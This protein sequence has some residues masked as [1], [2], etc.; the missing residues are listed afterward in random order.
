MSL[1]TNALIGEYLLTESLGAG[2]MGEVYKAVHTHLGRVIAVK[3]LSPGLTDGP[4]LQ[5][6]YNE[7]DI[8]ASLKHPSVAEY[9]GFY[10]YQGRPCILME[11]VDGETLAAVIQRRGA[12]PA[13]EALKIQQ[14][15]TAAIAH[16]HAQ[17]VV[18]RDIKTGNI[19]IT[20]SGQVKIL[21]FGIARHQR[22]DRL[23]RLGAVVG[24]TEYMA[25]EQV[26]GEP[27]GFATDVWQLGVLFYELLAGHLPFQ[28]ATTHEIYLRI[29]SGDFIPIR[30][31]RPDVPDSIGQIVSRC[32]Q[33]EPSRRYP[34]ASELYQALSSWD[35]SSAIAQ[36]VKLHRFRPAW[37]WGVPAF[38][39][40]A[41]AAII[42]LQMRDQN[43]SG[44]RGGGAIVANQN[45][46]AASG[47][48]GAEAS[49]KVITVDTMDGA[50]QVFQG[51]KAVGATPFK[52][53]ARVGDK[54]NIILRRDGF[55]DLPVQ[56]DVSERYFYTY[57]LMP[58]KDR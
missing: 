28:A 8:Q 14:E 17:G 46:E 32:L 4:A 43:D 34:S 56:F 37:A 51:E 11:Y 27:A 30:R 58:I 36:T 29:L 42:S 3:V 1:L 23:T 5:R 54:V 7:A 10:E 2:G 21:D 39:L 52:I 25:P 38:L 35:K 49:I 47:S 33:K 31:L 45:A 12:L 50:A 6:F 44:E 18:H 15:I 24:T 20:S 55:K 19:K 57:T 16:F 48:S 26:R 13:D 9:L 22:A 40:F 41:I 53:K